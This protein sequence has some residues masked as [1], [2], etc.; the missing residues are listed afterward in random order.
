M[1]IITRAAESSPKFPV[2]QIVLVVSHELVHEISVVV[3]YIW[4]M[5]WLL[6]Y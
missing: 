1:I 5:L 3:L 6:V 4:W 2:S